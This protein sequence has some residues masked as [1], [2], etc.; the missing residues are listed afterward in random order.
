VKKGKKLT[1]TV[2]L[3]ASAVFLSSCTAN[4]TS[5]EAKSRMF[6][7]LEP[8]VS[9][10]YETEALAQEKV[11]S[12]GDSGNTF[13]LFGEQ[14]YQKINDNLYRV[15]EKTADGKGFTRSSK[16]T[17]II[18]SAGTY[19]PSDKYFVAVDDYV[20]NRICTELSVELDT[21]KASDL[22]DSEVDGVKTFGLLHK[23]GYLKF[24]YEGNSWGNYE[25][26]NSKL[27]N[28][29][30]LTLEEM[31]T[32][33]FIRTYQSNLNSTVA[34]LKSTI[35][36]KS[37][38]YGYGNGDDTIYI[39]ATT[40]KQAWHKGGAV[41]E[42]L[43]VYPVA[44]LLDTFAHAFAHNDPSKFS[45]G[46][47]QI[48]ALLLVTVIV[49]LFIFVATIKSTFDQQK[50]T[51]LQPKIAEIQQKYPNANTN[52]SEKQRLAEEQMRLY[53]KYKVNPLST[54]LVMIVQFPVFIGVWGAMTGS[55]VLATGSILG[56]NLSGSIWKALTDFS[57]MS[58]GGGW[59]IALIL[60]LLMAV[61]QFVSMR[62]PT[63]FQKKQTKKVAKLG[64]NPAMTQQN[65]TANMMSWFMLVMIIV[66]GVSLPAAMGFYW[67]VGALV[68]VL[69]TV[70]TQLVI[71]KKI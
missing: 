2:G 26:M 11:A 6:Y 35:T 34:N 68:S 36:T 48:L 56:L 20:L 5:D 69:Q 4:F 21:I 47:P 38:E 17:S 54:I 45:T 51:K 61:S 14:S 7:N 28:D 10:Y 23:Y 12:V 64:K 43:I 22:N 31:P 50:M 13:Y 53:K 39:E 37:G 25:E 3:L 19:Q 8:G 52:Q 9:Y 40:W 44:W 49:R 58:F 32:S 70:I 41:I 67:F 71:K 55:A 65:K 1:L 24:G 42:G 18:S 27:V 60:F 57:D 66:M 59:W 62:L 33:D 29:S 63:W 46:I 30:V 15:V 16:L